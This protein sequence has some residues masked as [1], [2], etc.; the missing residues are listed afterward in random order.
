[1]AVQTVS[2]EMSV[3]NQRRLLKI[4]YPKYR[5]YND[6]YFGGKLP[7]LPILLRKECQVEGREAWGRFDCEATYSKVTRRIMDIKSYGRITLLTKYNVPDEH[8]LQTLLHEM[9]HAYIF[10]V[11]KRYPREAHGD[12]FMEMAQAI[13]AQEGLDIRP[14]NEMVD[15]SEVNQGDV[16]WYKDDDQNNDNN[17]GEETHRNGFDMQFLFMV[18]LNNPKVPFTYWV[19]RCPS[20]KLVALYKERLKHAF[21]NSN[22]VIS[23]KPCYV[24][25]IDKMPTDV[26]KLYGF[27]AY[28]LKKVT[29]K[30]GKY[31]GVN[32]KDIYNCL[33]QPE[34]NEPN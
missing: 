15:Y 25:G 32:P 30:I 33:A 11:L 13:S 14:E 28:T 8:Y 5:L 12:I 23:V 31:C 9:I 18:T 27:G 7:Q 19:V 24:H 20:M 4:L 17:N 1:M 29:E 10:L 3:D 16:D 2:N 22:A 6:E 26:N 21:E 34:N